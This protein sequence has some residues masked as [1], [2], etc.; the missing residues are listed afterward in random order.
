MGGS[1]SRTGPAVKDYFEGLVDEY[2]RR[3]ENKELTPCYLAAL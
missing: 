1:I 3:L 2:N